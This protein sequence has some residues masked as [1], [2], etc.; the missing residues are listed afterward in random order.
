MRKIKVNDTEIV[1][2]PGELQD[3]I[4]LTDMANEKKSASQAADI[5]K[6][7]IRARYTL[8]F[9]GTWEKINN[10]GSLVM[11]TLKIIPEMLEKCISGIY[12][13]KEYLPANN[14]SSNYFLFS[15]DI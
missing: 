14:V 5:I 7:W 9:I 8:E 12:I 15:G 1:I 2:L 11:P 13:N 10:T 3:Y 6:N 4:S